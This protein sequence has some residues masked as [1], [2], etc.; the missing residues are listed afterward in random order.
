MSSSKM[1]VLS[2][3][4]FENPEEEDQDPFNN[5]ADEQ[6]DPV[7]SDNETDAAE[8]FDAEEFDIDEENE[9][10]VENLAEQL[11]DIAEEAIQKNGGNL[12]PILLIEE[13]NLVD[14][15]TP[16]VDDNIRE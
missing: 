15:I 8:E 5:N 7:R 9:H 6:F 16:S 11:R 2:K 10:L 3:S 12:L 13:E 14:D 1:K 4:D